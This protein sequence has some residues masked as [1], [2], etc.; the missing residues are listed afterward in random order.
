[1]REMGSLLPKI[2]ALMLLCVAVAALA[3]DVAVDDIAAWEPLTFSSIEPNRVAIDNGALRISVQSSASPL[4]HRL[5]K[6]TRITG[7][8]VAA[9]WSGRLELAEGATQG[10][11]GADDFVL[12]FGIVEAGD[13]TLNWLQRRIAASWIK[14]LYSLAPRGT[15]VRRINFLSTTQQPELLGTRRTHPLNGLLQEERITLLKR[16]GAFAMTHRFDEP[17]DVL[18]LWIS[19]DGDDTGSSFDLVITR[20]ELHGEAPAER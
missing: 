17:V 3:S 9:S 11:K 7:I 19:S 10:E 12:K 6:P 8:S 5:E 20:I 4:V 13:Q 14:R 1:M 16:P 18:G 15:G 2:A